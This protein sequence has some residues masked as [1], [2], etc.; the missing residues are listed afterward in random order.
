MDRLAPVDGRL[1]DK[2]LVA[3]IHRAVHPKHFQSLL[4]ATRCDVLIVDECHHLSDWAPG[5]GDPTRKFKL[6]RELIERQAPGGRVVFLSGTPHQGSVA[7]I[8]EPSGPAP[9]RWRA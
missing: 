3:S 2:L 8:R 4:N 1:N 5:G 7:T 6:V 9:A